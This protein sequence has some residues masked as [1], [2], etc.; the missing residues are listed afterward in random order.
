MINL[1]PPDV[2][3]NYRYAHRNVALRTWVVAFLFAF[4]GLA[5]LTTYGVG[6]LRQSSSIYRGK[7]AQTEAYFQKEKYI[8]T[9]QQVQDMSNS[10]KL[11][12]QVLSKEVLFSQLLRQITTIIPANASL[13]G[14]SITNG[15]DAVDIS[16]NAADY[17]T[18]TQIQVNL[19]DPSNK[20]FIK[21]DI[22]S[23]TCSDTSSTDAATAGRPCKVSIRALFGPNN[24][25]LFINSKATQR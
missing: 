19:A 6:S 13:T 1:L 22:I 8:G 15:Q 17:K 25:Y 7:V 5:A 24:P 14:L 10:F 4:I 20:I 21:A 3:D 16:A 2:K 11:A 23:I 12:V 9:Q 18:A